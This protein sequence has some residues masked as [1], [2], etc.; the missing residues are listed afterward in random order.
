MS[1][2]CTGTDRFPAKHEVL[3]INSPERP[4]NGAPFLFAHDGKGVAYPIRDKDADN[5]W[6]QPLDGSPGKQITNFKSERIVDFHW[7]FDGNKLG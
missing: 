2:A 3:Y 5:L 7:S 4:I 6:L 1:G